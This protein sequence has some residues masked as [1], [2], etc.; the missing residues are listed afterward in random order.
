MAQPREANADSGTG[1]IFAVAAAASA[2]LLLF[3]PVVLL[4]Y[5]AYVLAALIS[6]EALAW[7]SAL[8]TGE[9]L[10]WQSSVA[11]TYTFV[12]IPALVSV[13]LLAVPYRLFK[14]AARRLG[15]SQAAF[16]VGGAVAVWHAVV[17]VYW[18]W[19]STEGLTH[20]P[21]GDVLWYPIVFG[22]V[23]AIATAFVDR[24]ALVVPLA[25]V[26]VLALLLSGTVR[27][28]TPIPDGAQQVDIVVS[29]SQV[30]LGPTT[31]D[32]G[33][34]YLLLDTP[35]S[36]VTFTD[37]ELLPTDF[38]TRGE[39]DLR[40]CSDAQRAEDRGQMGYCGNVFKVTLS[41]GTYVFF[42]TD[43]DGSGQAL[44]RLEVVP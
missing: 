37:E 28:R 6:G 21:T 15:I 33:E 24:R 2:S 10:A 27:S 9:A 4:G 22:I 13:L 18:A 38:P 43:A 39:F 25:L 42:S 41:A 20:A 12:G 5:T 11:M 16:V 14:A 32:A 23:A 30:R 44:A 34:V 31:V 8:I 35:R 17:A 19:A 26:G 7:Q 40:G 3:L 36:S 29:S 1:F